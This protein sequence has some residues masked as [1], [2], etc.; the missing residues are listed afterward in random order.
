MKR[1]VYKPFGPSIL[2][3]Q[4]PHEIIDKLNEYTETRLSKDLDKLNINVGDQLAGNVSQEIMIETEALKLS[5]FDNFLMN[6]CANWIYSSSKQKIKKFNLVSSWIVRQF[7][8]EY[9]PLHTHTGHV[10]GVGYLKVPNNLGE[11]KQTNKP[12]KNGYL[13]LV[14]GSKN[15]MSQSVF[16]I[17]PKVGD[18][19]FFPHYL[20]HVVYPFC[21]TKEERRSVSFNAYIDNEIYSSTD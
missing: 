4:I 3:V 21:D 18:F 12:N 10:S 5:G 7:Q 11:T 19:Y 2:K 6:E 9:N 14:H 15:F 8:N 1:L 16:N 13:Q 17:K 20:M